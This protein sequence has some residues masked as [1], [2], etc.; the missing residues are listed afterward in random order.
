MLAPCAGWGPTSRGW[1]LGRQVLGSTCSRGVHASP[2]TGSGGLSRQWRAEQAGPQ[3]C[4]WILLGCAEPI[5]PA[6][7][8]V[9]PKP[10][11]YS[12]LGGRSFSEKHPRLPMRWHSVELSLPGCCQSVPAPCQALSLRGT[13]PQ[14]CLVPKAAAPHQAASPAPHSPDEVQPLGWG[15]C[16]LDPIARDERRLFSHQAPQTHPRDVGVLPRAPLLAIAWALCGTGMGRG[17]C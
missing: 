11:S 16:H 10:D 6:V 5:D 9:T 3:G 1:V 15:P 2:E 4:N 13:L 12:T 17:A 14:D 8:K 7:I